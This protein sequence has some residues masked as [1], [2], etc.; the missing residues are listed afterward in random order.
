MPETSKRRGPKPTGQAL[1]GA[2]RQRRYMQRLKGKAVTDRV[3]APA[4]SDE[5]PAA[6]ARIAELET[7]VA[8]LRTSER[9]SKIEA[10]RLTR[11]RDEARA[12]LAAIKALP[13]RPSPAQ[14][15]VTDDKPRG[16]PTE[17][18]A[19]AVR[20][21]D[22]G[23]ETKEIRAAILEACGKAPDISNLARLMRQWRAALV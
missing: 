18:K 6:R 10:N 15:T 16:Y 23:K 7:L 2:E 1:S 8:N 21:A 14:N 3:S 13:A 20:M 5:L 22:E 11:E 17:V 12:E 19:L 9:A 4:V